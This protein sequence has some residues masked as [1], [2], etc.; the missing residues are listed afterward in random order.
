MR[1]GTA[2]RQGQGERSKIYKNFIPFLLACPAYCGE[3]RN[4]R[5]L[6]TDTGGFVRHYPRP[7]VGIQPPGKDAMTVMYGLGAVL[8]LFLFGYLL[9]ALLRAE[10]F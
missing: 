6:S 7:G 3:C 8:A 10:R 4:G 5:Y 2:S 9:F 1:T